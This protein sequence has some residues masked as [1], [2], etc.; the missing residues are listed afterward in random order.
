M[1]PNA[2][3]D[4][5]PRPASDAPKARRPRKRRTLG[6]TLLKL[7][8]VLVIV[9]AAIVALLPALAG[10]I[11]KG[12]IEQ[13]AAKQIN[14]SLTINTLGL[15]WLGEQRVDATL[16]DD[17]GITVGDVR[18]TVTRG[19]LGI[20]TNLS[21]QTLVK[22]SGDL[23]LT[24][25]A[26]G[27]TN[28]QRILNLPAPSAAGS[29]APPAAPGDTDPA[30]PGAAD[31]ASPASRPGSPAPRT[32]AS[33]PPV[34]P[35]N[36][37]INI[38][39]LALRLTDDQLAAQTA[40]KVGFAA[41]EIKD[42]VIAASTNPASTDPQ[43]NITIQGTAGY[44]PQGATQAS[45]PRPISLSLTV[46]DALS[47]AGLPDG[48][49]A[50]AKGTVALD[51]VPIAL[52][53]ALAG[54]GGEL[55]A[56]ADTATLNI[57]LDKPAGQP[58]A[59]LD[60]A[61]SSTPAEAFASRLRLQA[62]FDAN[63]LTRVAAPGDSGPSLTR[64]NS[65]LLAALMPAEQRA[66]LLGP[67]GTA[68]MRTY[69]DVEV[70]INTLS[71]PLPPQQGAG[72]AKPLSLAALAADVTLR[73][74]ETAATLR[75][76]TQPGVA[77]VPQQLRLP[78]SE[79]ALVTR[80]LAQGV[81]LTA[82][83]SPELDGRPAGTL[84]ANINAANLLDAQ[85]QIS[86]AA[87]SVAGEITA[88]DLGLAVV[89]PFIPP[90][91]NINIIEALGPTLT[92]A[93]QAET[94][95]APA[96]AASA[97]PAAAPAIPPLRVTL[98]AKADRLAAGGSLRLDNQRLTLDNNAPFNMETTGLTPIA[99]ALLKDNP[100]AA[101][102]SVGR[103][104][105][106]VTTL[107]INLDDLA[108]GDLRAL[109]AA[110]T[111]DLGTTRGSLTVE[112]QPRRTFETAPL[113]L[114]VNVP[115]L[116]QGLTANV[117]GGLSVDGQ[118]AGTLNADIN[119]KGLLTAEGAP[120]PG[121]PEQLT[122]EAT[123]TGLS[124]IIAQPFLEASG[125]DVAK[126]IGPTLDLALRAATIPNPTGTNP[127]APAADITISGT[128]Q[129][130]ALNG[131]FRY[132]PDAITLQGQ[133]LTLT[134]KAPLPLLA[135]LAPMQ[136]GSTWTSTSGAAGNT[137]SFAASLT[138]ATVPLGKDGAPL[139]ARADIAATVALAGI[140]LR[141]AAGGTVALDDLLLALTLTPTTDPALSARGAFRGGDAPGAAAAP[142]SL[143]VD[144]TL[145][146]LL[147]RNADGT[148]AFT[149]DTALPAGSIT[150]D[151]VSTA[152]IEAF[153]P[154][155][156]KQQRPPVQDLVGPSLASTIN[157]KPASRGR[158]NTNASVKSERITLT[159][160]AQIDRAALTPPPAAADGP[161]PSP[162]AALTSLDA[163]GSVE[164]TP[165]AVDRLLA[166]Y[167]ADAPVNT[168]LTRPGRVAFSAKTAGDTLNA[169]LTRLALNLKN[170]AL[171]QADG[172][173]RSLAAATLTGTGTASLP[174]S[175]TG[176]VAATFAGVI[177][178]AD[179]SG[180][181]NVGL[182][183]STALAA[184]GQPMPVDV[185]L[186][187][188]GPIVRYVDPLA[189][190]P[191]L[192]ISAAGEGRSI[193]AA[194]KGSLTDG[195]PVGNANLTLDT[196]LL[197]TASPLKVALKPGN[198]LSLL[199]PTTLNY[200][201]TAAFA[202][203]QLNKPANT[204]APATPGQ[205]APAPAA[206]PA[207]LDR[208]VPVTINLTHLMVPPGDPANAQ[209]NAAVTTGPVPLVLQ[210]NVPYA[211]E[212]IAA[213]AATGR[214]NSRVLRAQVVRAGKDEIDANLQL[215]PNADP[216][217]LPLLSGT[218]NVNQFPAALLDALA[219]SD[220]ASAVLGNQATLKLTA[221]DFP[222]NGSTFG[223]TLD[224]PQT[225]AA[226][227]ARVEKVNGQ[228]TIVAVGQPSIRVD[229]I[230]QEFSGK[231]AFFFPYFA[232]IAKEPGK[233]QPATVTITTLSVPVAA[234][235]KLTEAGPAQNIRAAGII[236]PGSGRFQIAGPVAS[237]VNIAGIN[238][239][240]EFG[241]SFA[242]IRFTVDN[243]YVDIDPF[244]IPVG[245][246]STKIDLPV[247]GQTRFAPGPL[248][249]STCLN[250]PVGSLLGGGKDGGQGGPLKD[251]LGD[252]NP[253]GDLLG[254]GN[255][256]PG[257]PNP[258][259]DLINKGIGQV[260]GNKGEGASN[261]LTGGLGVLGIEK[262]GDDPVKVKLGCN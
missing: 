122:G 221:K 172:S 84:A 41:I 200:T 187:V 227:N 144:L 37:R 134:H 154:P 26:A 210:G 83:A 162:L 230:T 16:A 226:F 178:P 166:M 224:A 198:A 202:N 159:A 192:L 125:V 11:A 43:V 197:K 167:A 120:R 33:A 92:L 228:D 119:A 259:G 146:S 160:A 207:R 249:N 121:L 252:K 208:D 21:A 174:L 72:A 59:T 161:A 235:T 237:A 76:P 229:R 79:I 94:L 49:A 257:E 176:P 147:A 104:A 53:D 126:D 110:A 149:P 139:L 128:S 40:G 17:A 145:Q 85:G 109:A 129:Q 55:A 138:K 157:F 163:S 111:V 78:P 101:V 220:V 212:R 169:E 90:S 108:K 182:N 81:Q 186:T 69:P 51:A 25:D 177:T 73:L 188:D 20:A 112:G 13:I 133:G 250:F 38:E 102:T 204:P 205:P 27:L 245:G 223:L 103:L 199:E 143:A 156:A 180:P 50:S 63:T 99:K 42:S 107:D 54:L 231:L 189:G 70:R 115:S 140:G 203:A 77:P 66:S 6:G 60:L 241:E 117:T 206:P 61:A 32:G 28:L 181:I 193:A 232:D 86:P 88:T 242:D 74:T 98:D 170:I 243:G 45:N 215:T 201:L 18:I 36:V 48:K 218:V 136:D 56:V 114:A 185:A 151:N 62:D 82:S 152:L 209:V 3:P 195:A 171:E 141:T 31:P 222:A 95:A 196:G 4:A 234:L 71:L 190:D 47:P 113:R 211:I 132:T 179:N 116:A 225:D 123:L 127:A 8:V 260:T 216:K 97:A 137:G 7:A 251:I 248:C 12:Q 261:P 75:V 57:A 65:R 131:A 240:S 91:A 93:V 165:A 255:A 238:T 19:L 64:I 148:A 142:G 175:G 118:P 233:D 39:R 254:G 29:P 10:P 34:P 236:D 184:A 244:I 194:F 35:L 24:R 130:V 191:G 68:E 5:T 106:Q 256:K 219:G 30:A 80:G 239:S 183:A 262:C 58:I 164:L 153:I 213:S 67:G 23:S 247:D 87:P 135:R 173:V 96:P 217:A 105:A 158:L 2:N 14:G 124:T 246:G 52:L 214:N 155:D 150:I 22:V 258:L 46:N 9:L 15:S 89:Q 100:A 44:G 1:A 168:G 253:L